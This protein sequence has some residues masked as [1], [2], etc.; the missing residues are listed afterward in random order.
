MVICLQKQYNGDQSESWISSLWTG[1]KSVDTR[2]WVAN[3]SESL[4]LP[5]VQQPPNSRDFHLRRYCQKDTAL[6]STVCKV[7]S[8]INVPSAIG[9]PT[10]IVGLKIGRVSSALGRGKIFDRLSITS[11]LAGKITSLVKVYQAAHPRYYLVRLGSS[12]KDLPRI[13]Y[14]IAF[15]S[16]LFKFYPLTPTSTFGVLTLDQSWVR[17]PHLDIRFCRRFDGPHCVDILLLGVAPPPAR[18]AAAPIVGNS[19]L[20]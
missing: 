19:H 17:F 20:A 15:C 10:T 3:E 4:A 18:H 1:R 14:N 9:R 2:V 6:T 13:R 11:C 12:P 8:P 5:H 16:S 7:F